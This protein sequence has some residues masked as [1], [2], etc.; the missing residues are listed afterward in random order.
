MISSAKTW[1]ENLV[2]EESR[3][4][5]GIRADDRGKE[6]CLIAWT[7]KGKED[8]GGEIMNLRLTYS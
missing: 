5:E 2:Q 8:K 1:N 3:R 6:Q 4:R 7:K